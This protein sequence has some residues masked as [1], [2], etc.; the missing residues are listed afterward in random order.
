MSELVAVLV[1]YLLVITLVTLWSRMRSK[2]GDPVDYFIASRGLTGFISAMTYAATTFSAF[3]MVGL[4]GLSYATGVGALVFELAYLISTVAIL[5]T[6]GIRVWEISRKQGY[7][8]PTQLLR[9]KYGSYWTTVLVVFMT[10]IA[11]V[12]YSA[13]QVVGP[14]TI[15]SVISRGTI[16]Y[17][18]AVTISA[19]IVLLTTL[20]AGL[21]SVAWTDAVQGTIMLS[22]AIAFAAWLLSRVPPESTASLGNLELLSPLNSFWTPQVLVAYTTPWI[23]FAIT[24]P[25]VFQRLY[26]PK[27]RRAYTKMV[28]YFSIFGLLYTVITVSVGLAARALSEAGI[29]TLQI[30]V[31]SRADWNRVTPL[32][33]TYAHPVLSAITAIS[34]I[35]AATSTVNSIALT[36]SSMVSYDTP[37]PDRLKLAVGKIVVIAFTIVIY[38][39]ALTT[40]A[41]VVDLAVASSTI[42]LPLLPIYLFSIYGYARKLP[43]IVTTVTCLPLSLYLTLAKGVATPIPKEVLVVL[44]SFSTYLVTVLVSESIKKIKQTQR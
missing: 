13:V 37:V 7:I 26:L 2:T 36:I 30:D 33:L 14:A 17:R 24:N 38:V 25:Q 44:V 23:F 12:P 8:T 11:L 21:R 32:L 39:F 9:E 41:F 22:S 29:L 6:V 27:D 3:M 4:V 10:A 19:A 35:S 40:P 15:L 28:L 16:D 34:I 1:G 18:T 20:T 42:L 31:R 5:S 43:Y